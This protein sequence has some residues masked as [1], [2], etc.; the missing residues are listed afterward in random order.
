MSKLIY[1]AIIEGNLNFAE[2]LIVNIDP[3][4]LTKPVEGI[5]GTPTVLSVAVRKN[6]TEYN[7]VS[8]LIVS[9]N[10]DTINQIETNC[11]GNQ[12]LYYTIVS[13][14]IELFKFV[15][16]HIKFNVSTVTTNKGNIMHGLANHGRWEQDLQKKSV[17]IDT[18]IKCCELFSKKFPDVTTELIKLAD[19]SDLTP[20][21]LAAS[22]NEDITT[23]FLNQVPSHNLND[24]AQADMLGRIINRKY[25]QA[26]EEIIAN[27]PPEALSNLSYYKHTPLYEAIKSELTKIRDL[28]Y[29][30]MQFAEISNEEK[31]ALLSISIEKKYDDFCIK[32][33]SGL[34]LEQLN[35]KDKIKL[36]NASTKSGCEKFSIELLSHMSAEL[37]NVSDALTFASSSKMLKVCKIVLDKTFAD[38]AEQDELKRVQKELEEFKKSA[39]EKEAVYIAQ[40]TQMKQ[41]LEIEYEEKILMREQIKVLESN[42]LKVDEEGVNLGQKIIEDM[43]WS[44]FENAPANFDQV[45]A[46]GLDDGNS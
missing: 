18:A 36:L 12:I 22:N 1:D 14:N 24:L 21:D 20:F 30:K 35:P 27:T 3:R 19:P 37:V 38:S 6:T 4:E 41:Q 45:E 11:F 8:K 40:I 15:I 28:L 44:I 43:S 39:A 34:S 5:R 13:N 9:R 2:H 23:W 25:E 46:L 31:L 42:A 10:P 26:A 33:C 17:L 7:E 32:L 29:N 16:N